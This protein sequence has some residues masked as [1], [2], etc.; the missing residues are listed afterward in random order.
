MCVSLCPSVSV[1]VPCVSVSVRV[2]CVCVSVRVPCVSVSVRV[3]VSLCEC[4]C[5][6]ECVL[7]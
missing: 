6:S 5:A 3:S 1:R 7:V 4:E 2:P